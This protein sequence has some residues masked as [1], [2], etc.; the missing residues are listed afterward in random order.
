MGHETP[1]LFSLRPKTGNEEED[2]KKIDLKPKLVVME[3]EIY[4][5]KETEMK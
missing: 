3:T 5:D 4:E 2:H 1:F